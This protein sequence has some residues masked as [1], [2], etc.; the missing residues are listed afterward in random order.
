MMMKRR[1]MRPLAGLFSLTLLAAACGDDDDEGSTDDTTEDTA[2]EDT[3]P[4]ADALALGVLFPE[5]GSLSAIIGALRTPVDLAMGEINAAGGVLGK[6]VTIAAADDG[7]DD[8]N[9][10]SASLE[11][12]VSSSGINVLLGPASS[13]LTEALMDEIRDADVVA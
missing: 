12:L 10:A 5:S 7:T 8:A 6:P 1:W 11:S 3:R 4:E 2:A 9:L 13:D